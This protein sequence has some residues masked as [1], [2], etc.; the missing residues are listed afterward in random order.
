MRL[1][2]KCPRRLLNR[3]AGGKALAEFPKNAAVKLSYATGVASALE[4]EQTI[5]PSCQRGK[6][7]LCSAEFGLMNPNRCN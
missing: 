4:T 3:Q 1:A 5:P 6:E 7:G 2:T